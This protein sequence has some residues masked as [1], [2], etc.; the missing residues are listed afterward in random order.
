MSN[1]SSKPDARVNLYR[2]KLT[3][4]GI[5]PAERWIF[6]SIA[7]QRLFCYEGA[8]LIKEYPC[9]T[10]AKPPSCQYGSNGTPPGLH[11]IAEKIGA[12]AA[13]G[14]IFE[15]RADTGKTALEDDTGKTYITS[16]ILWLEG[17][18]EGKN[19]GYECGSY[20]RK[21][22]IHGINREEKIGSPWSNGCVEMKND[23]VIGLFDWV[24]EG[25]RVLID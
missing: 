3:L 9:S 24:K 17:L 13:R 15:K 5:E 21:I 2:A 19:K 1:E 22:Y 16:R 12:G 10:S 23:D 25:D 11:K 7:A 4:C 14:A 20:N 8:R 6:V 18:E